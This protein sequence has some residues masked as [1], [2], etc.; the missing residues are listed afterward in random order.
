MKKSIQEQ[1]I[2]SIVLTPYV[3]LI[4]EIS[5]NASIHCSLQGIESPFPGKQT[6]YPRLHEGRMVANVLINKTPL[7]YELQAL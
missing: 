3:W 6:K 5:T 7:G 1:S 4:Q 2:G